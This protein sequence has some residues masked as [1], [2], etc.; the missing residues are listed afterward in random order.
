MDPERSCRSKNTYLTKAQAK[1]VVRFMGE[2]HREQFNLYRCEFCGYWHIGHLVPAI[3]R[4]HRVHDFERTAVR[5][6]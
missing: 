3:F 4:A 6:A 2:R 5:V 1:A